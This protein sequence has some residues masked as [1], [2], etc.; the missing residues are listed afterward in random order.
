LKPN[1]FKLLSFNNPGDG[2]DRSDRKSCFG[3]IFPD[4][5]QFQLGKPLE[6]KVFQ[7]SVQ[8]L[9]PGHKERKMEINVDEWEKCRQCADF[10]NCYEFSMAKLEMQRAL[11]EL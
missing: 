7:I 9:G 2:K 4:L 10:R 5:G 6:G 1:P 3:S 11:R 8:S